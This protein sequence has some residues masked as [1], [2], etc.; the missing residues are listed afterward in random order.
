MNRMDATIHLNPEK[1]MM[2][3]I[4][5]R[6]GLVQYS[7]I[8]SRAACCDV[9]K[10]M[11]FQ[12][13]FNGYYR[14]RRNPE[15]CSHYYA[16]FEAMKTGMPTFEYII[17]TLYDRSGNIEASFASKM[18]ATLDTSKPIW[19]QYVL[20]RLHMKLKENGKQEK[21]R[22]AITL[23]AGIADWYTQYLSTDE[24]A[25]CIMVFNRYLPDYA[26]ISDVKKLDFFLW[27]SR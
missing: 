22:N 21:L 20:S 6:L 23:Y 4:A 13:L 12:R 14:V 17:R 1:I 11:E 8:L 24:S 7:R 2:E 9:S 10:D 27:S 5:S 19:D 16:L 26:W 3:R 25:S 18:L 15:W